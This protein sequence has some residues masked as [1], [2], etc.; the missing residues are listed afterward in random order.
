MT[1][2]LA[3]SGYLFEGQLTM[4]AEP[5]RPPWLVIQNAADQL[6]TD[7]SA[8]NGNPPHNIH[9]NRDDPAQMEEFHRRLESILASTG[10]DLF[11]RGQFVG[12]EEA[13]NAT[14]HVRAFL[15]S[16]VL[17]CLPLCCS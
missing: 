4:G 5:P 17:V 6:L 16:L 12:L 9:V 11:A 7:M 15:F 2:E 14:L 1:C 10:T 8:E 13:I 3:G